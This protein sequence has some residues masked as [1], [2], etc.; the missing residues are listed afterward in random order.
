VSDPFEYDDAAYVLGALSPERTAEFEDHLRGCDACTARVRE[1]DT[2]PELLAGV[3]AEEVVDDIPDTVLPSLLRAAAARRRR[4]RLTVGALVAVAAACVIALVVAVWPSTGTPAGP[5]AKSFAAVLESP[6]RAS[7]TLTA[8]S[9]GTAIDLHCR[10]VAGA[11][12]AGFSY[13]LVA[14]DRSGARHRLGDWM[15]PPGRAIDYATGTSLTRAQIARLEITLP[16]GT[17]VLRLTT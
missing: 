10:Y 6:V 11:T 1:I 15:L 3:T 7:A 14:V 12:D 4:Q 16:D 17:P 5:P 9:W 13:Q 8:K 2:V